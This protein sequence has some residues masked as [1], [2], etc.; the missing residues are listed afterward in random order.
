[1]LEQIAVQ[2]GHGPVGEGQADIRGP[3]PGNPNQVLHLS[4][5]DSRWPSG[6]I[7]RAL[8]APEPKPIEVGQAAVGRFFCTSDPSPSGQSAQASAHQSNELIA[9]GYPHRQLPVMHLGFQSL[10]LATAEAP[11]L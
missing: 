8:E 1:M 6:R 9:M 2:F 11:Q 7:G 5:L 3:L 4:A 10:R